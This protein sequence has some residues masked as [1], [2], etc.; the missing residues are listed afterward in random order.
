MCPN[1]AKML[2]DACIILKEIVKTIFNCATTY[3][4]LINSWMSDDGV[5]TEEYSHEEMRNL[6]AFY[7]LCARIWWYSARWLMRT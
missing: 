4:W 1:L 7:C 5:E 3:R 2:K 6:D